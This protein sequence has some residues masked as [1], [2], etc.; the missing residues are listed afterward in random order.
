MTKKISLTG[1]IPET[2]AGQRIDQS[3]A[4]IFPEYSRAR[5][6]TWLKNGHVTVNNRQL[7]PKDRILGN[8]SI[9]INAVLE[10]ET[11]EPEAIALDII[12]ED[13]ALI[14]IN[15]PAGLVVHPAHGN[16][17][18]TL[19]NAL[20]HHCPEL[21][22]LPRAGLIHRLDKDTTGLLVIAK[23]LPNH[24]ALV[25]AMQERRI[26]R[27]YQ[28]IVYGKT[29]PKGTIRTNMARHPHQR[30]KMAVS[31]SL[32][33]KPAVTHYTRLGHY[34]PFSHL[35]VKL[36]TGRTHQ[37]RVHMAH[38]KLPI[39]GD[40][41]YGISGKQL[42]KYSK[43]SAEIRT[44]FSTFDRQALHAYKLSLVHP[45]TG[46]IMQWKAPLPED[47]KQLLHLMKTEQI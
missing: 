24:H 47:I 3:L 13:S 38:V 20:L 22:H 34:A 26:Q 31:A 42:E 7:K 43:I 9:V 29:P 12:Y 32:I 2:F 27:T 10:E 18:H 45:E 35:E 30:L 15:K 5:L 41:L 17:E 40:P 39:V 23:T 14:V 1:V 4:Q 46:A 33:G 44:F 16:Y 6:T 19:V 11:W 28:T 21:I 8:E 36:E 37:I 25:K